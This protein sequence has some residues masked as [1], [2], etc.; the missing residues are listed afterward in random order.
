MCLCTEHV[1][2]GEIVMNYNGWRGRREEGRRRKGRKAGVA[3]L[4]CVGV[5]LCWSTHAQLHSSQALF[6]HSKLL[7]NVSFCVW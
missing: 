6:V 3:C 1:A 5:V 7:L 4:E 2:A